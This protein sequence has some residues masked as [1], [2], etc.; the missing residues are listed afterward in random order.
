MPTDKLINGHKSYKNEFK[1]NENL[2]LHL[3]EKGQKPKV[4][5]IGCSDSRVVPEQIMG[6]QPGDLFVHRN[7]ANIIPPHAS[8]ENCTAA[9]IKYA[10]NELQVRHIV[11]CGHTE[12]GG[13]KAVIN[14]DGEK[15][16][17]HIGNWISYADEAKQRV[18][19]KNTNE[20]SIYL[21]TI[22]ENV[23]QQKKHLLTYDFINE[24]IDSH[25][26]N[27]HLWLYDLHNGSILSYNDTN[28]MWIELK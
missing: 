4:L 11:I 26:L 23:L 8:K 5:W 20:N 25:V 22:K 19:E 16:S 6:A 14:S 7:I 24:K 12:C 21:E 18:N 13:I 15:N 10:V 9:A 1:K 17:C 27:I 3:A 28:K 2:F